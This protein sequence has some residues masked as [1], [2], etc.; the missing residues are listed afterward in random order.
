[1]DELNFTDSEL[2]YHVRNA[3]KAALQ[4][5]LYEIGLDLL[6]IN[7]SYQLAALNILTFNLFQGRLRLL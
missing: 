1:M 3:L 4:V 7:R 2:D 6:S 5:I